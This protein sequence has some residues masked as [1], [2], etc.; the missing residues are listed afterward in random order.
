MVAA[1]V[2]PRGVCGQ[3]RPERSSA[4]GNPDSDPP[5]DRSRV[6]GKYATS[7]AKRNSSF[8]ARGPDGGSWTSGRARRA[9]SRAAGGGPEP[10]RPRPPCRPGR[11]S[12]GMRR[13]RYR[14]PGRT[15]TGAFLNREL[16]KANE[17]GTVTGHPSPPRVDAGNPPWG[18]AD[19]R[20]QSSV[21]C[22]RHDAFG[23]VERAVQDARGCRLG[24]RRVSIPENGGACLWPQNIVPYSREIDRQAAR[25]EWNPMKCDAAAESCCDAFFERVRVIRPQGSR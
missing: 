20:A 21:A 16:R 22:C 11:K 4:V 15:W 19:L 14:R 1:G 25:G 8:A 2:P 17:R 23:L 12:R 18:G 5:T 24:N 7:G 6:R 13:D 10:L 3:S 9:G